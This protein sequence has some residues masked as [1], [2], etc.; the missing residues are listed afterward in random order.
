MNNQVFSFF[1]DSYILSISDS[2]YYQTDKHATFNVIAESLEL[3]KFHIQ[4]YTVDLQWL[5]P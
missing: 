2:G 5:E 3:K 1:S 4:Y